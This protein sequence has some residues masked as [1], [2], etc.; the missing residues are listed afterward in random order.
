MEALPPVCFHVVTMPRR[1]QPP[2]RNYLPPLRKSI[3]QSRKSLLNPWEL[4]RQV[5]SFLKEISVSYKMQANFAG[6]M[7]D[8]MKMEAGAEDKADTIKTATERRRVQKDSF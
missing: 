4:R 1:L 2:Y 8:K 3:T 5:T 7:Y 6:G